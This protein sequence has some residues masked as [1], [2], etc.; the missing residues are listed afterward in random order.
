MVKPIF[1]PDGN[2]LENGKYEGKWEYT[3]FKEYDK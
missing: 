1:L 3:E 2:T